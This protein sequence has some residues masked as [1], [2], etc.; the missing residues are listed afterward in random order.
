[1]ELRPITMDDLP[2]YERL[3]TDERT[4]SELGGPLPREGLADKLR[5]IVADVESGKN[6][7][8]TIHPDDVTGPVG[9]VCVWEHDTDDMGTI[10]EIGWMVLPEFQGRG[11]AT[12]AVAEVLDL[13]RRTG[14]W[15]VI[16]A[17]PGE[18]NA[19]SNAIARKNGFERLELV[20]F[21]YAGRPMR[22]YH[23]RVELA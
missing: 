22:G 20:E 1:V 13:A 7:F 16:H 8:F 18:T 17:Y 12:A 19:P 14:R 4:M 11:L 2:L 23:W 9:S 15:T 10:S 21:E 5:T 3:L 6:W